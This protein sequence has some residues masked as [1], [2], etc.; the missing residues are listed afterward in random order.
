MQTWPMDAISRRCGTIGRGSLVTN[1][2][3]STL[4]LVRSTLWTVVLETGLRTRQYPARRRFIIQ[5]EWNAGMSVRRL[6][7]TIIA[8]RM[9]RLLE[10]GSDQKTKYSPWASHGA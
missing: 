1:C 5:P 8:A 2:M 10:N 6:A 3:Q 4:R 7:L 9:P